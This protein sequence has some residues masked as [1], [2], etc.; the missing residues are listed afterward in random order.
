MTVQATK[1]IDAGIKRGPRRQIDRRPKSA[2]AHARDGT[3]IST[4]SPELKAKVIEEC[5]TLIATGQTP[6]E[7]AT[8]N[9]LSPRT[10][11]YWLLG[12][13]KAEEA[14][15]QLIAAELART[16]Q[17]M[18]KPE[19]GEED[20]PLRLARAREEFRA[21]SWIAERRQARLYGQQNKLTVEVK[22][23]LGDRLRRARERVIDAES[24]AALPP[25]LNNSAAE[26]T[27]GTD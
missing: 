16:L 9:G 6:A 10:V 8:R 11:Q 14:R 5:R 1:R 23:D 17:D 19:D 26:S 7:I 25:V 12:D 18:R 3:F 27:Q 13:E 4:I 21:W 24:T 20:S 15:G 22:D 2:N